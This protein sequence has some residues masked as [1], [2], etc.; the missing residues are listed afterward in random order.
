[1]RV[2]HSKE[3]LHGQPPENAFIAY[4]EDERPVGACSISAQHKPVLYPEQPYRIYIRTEGALQALDTLL[5]AATARSFMLMRE[6]GK[7]RARIFTACAPEDS[8]KMESLKAL[9]FDMA[10][11]H[12]CYRENLPSKM[13]SPLCNHRTDQYGGCFENRARFPLMVI[14]RIRQAVGENFLLEAVISAEEPEGGY[15]LD[16]CVEFLKLTEKDLDIV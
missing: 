3:A 1:M 13:L 5:G 11:I 6:E 15:T 10:A 8:E 14:R 9:G 4:D 7:S 16:Q 12:M 2:R